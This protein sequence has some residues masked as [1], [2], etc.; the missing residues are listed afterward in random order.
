M[1]NEHIKNK[2]I[3]TLREIRS[4]M[5]GIPYILRPIK[6]YF[7]CFSI[8]CQFFPFEIIRE[9]HNYLWL[10]ENIEEPNN[11]KK[12]QIVSAFFRVCGSCFKSITSTMSS[13]MNDENSM[14]DGEDEVVQETSEQW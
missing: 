8:V 9:L 1:T 14:S 5:K 11:L 6:K 10:R 2:F 13:F 3:E 7:R 12:E 4:A